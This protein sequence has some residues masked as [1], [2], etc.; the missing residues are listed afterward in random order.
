MT[1]LVI[2]FYYNNNYNHCQHY[3]ALM[4]PLKENTLN[5]KCGANLWQ[6]NCTKELRV[7][8]INVFLFSNLITGKYN[9][10]LFLDFG[11]I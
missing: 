7:N 5:K 10:F 6:L 3:F 1:C 2:Q 9:N 8:R 4:E 11:R